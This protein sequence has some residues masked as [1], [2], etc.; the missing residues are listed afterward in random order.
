MSVHQ[1]CCASVYFFVFVFEIAMQSPIHIL[2][3]DCFAVGVFFCNDLSLQLLIFFFFLFEYLGMDQDLK[4][5]CPN[6]DM[7]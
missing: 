2:L 1:N 7:K 4:E 6:T 3:V 5:M